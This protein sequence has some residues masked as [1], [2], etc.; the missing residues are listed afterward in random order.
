MK[1]FGLHTIMFIL[2]FAGCSTERK[3]ESIEDVNEYA[4]GIWVGNTGS[5]FGSMVFWK[6]YV[7]NADGTYIQYYA[8]AS[9]DNWG[10]P[11]ESG[12]WVARTDKYSNSGERFFSLELNDKPSLQRFQGRGLQYAIFLSST[13]L[14]YRGTAEANVAIGLEKGDKFPFSK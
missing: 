3:V 9:S 6:K 12:T 7:I 13:K 10:E 8:M 5:M 14:Q 11:F 1:A 4:P 2:L